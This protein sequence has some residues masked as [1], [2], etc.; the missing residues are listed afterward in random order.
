MRGAGKTAEGR[1]GKNF[2][3]P[4]ISGTGYELPTSFKLANLPIG[5]NSFPVPE[6][7][8]PKLMGSPGTCI[9]SRRAHSGEATVSPPMLLG[10]PSPTSALPVHAK[11]GF[12]AGDPGAKLGFCAGDPGAELVLGVPR[13]ELGL[14]VP[15]GQPA[16]FCPRFSP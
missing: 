11:L 4:V 10:T 6:I 1:W 7:L 13:A 9:E 14:G 16:L 3:H 2:S 15:G 5:C 8:S 12:C